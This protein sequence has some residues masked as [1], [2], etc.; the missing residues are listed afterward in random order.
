MSG[1]PVVVTLCGSTRFRREYQLAFYE[2]EHAGHICLSVPCYKND[3]CCKSPAD[4]ARLDAHHRRK[5]DMSTEILVI[6]PD[7]YIGDSTGAEI[8]Y[9]ESTGK[10]VRYWRGPKSPPTAEFRDTGD[11][12]E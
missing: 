3:P 11:R 9:A 5:I 8:E 6:S 10:R 7:G 4:H 12:N 2:E 1:S